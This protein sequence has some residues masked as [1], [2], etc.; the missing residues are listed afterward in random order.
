MPRLVPTAC[1]WVRPKK[2]TSAGITSSPPPM[3]L[4]APIAPPSAS[5]PITVV[6]PM[7]TLSPF[8]IVVAP[9]DSE[10]AANIPSW[11]GASRPSFPLSI[12]EWIARA[13][14]PKPRKMRAFKFFA[15]SPDFHGRIWRSRVDS[16]KNATR[17]SRWPIVG[18]APPFT[19]N[20][21][22]MTQ[23]L[24]PLEPRTH[25]SVTMSAD[26]WTDITPSSDTRTIFVSSSLGDD[27]NDGTSPNF[28]VRTLARGYGQLRNGK[29]DHLLLRTGDVWEETF[30][31]W[32][33][34]GRSEQEPIVVGKYGPND[35]PLILAGSG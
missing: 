25:L 29:P 11:L 8:R 9:D 6:T 31:K 1:V 7:R 22:R 5:S 20:V 23:P 34:S 26:G 27:R 17:S 18:R 28:P 32:R 19:D 2:N 16:Y 21:I 35:K 14:R 12:P 13:G 4:T 24:E 15:D 10:P 30:P 3:P 33:L